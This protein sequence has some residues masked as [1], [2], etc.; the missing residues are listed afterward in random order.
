MIFSLL[1]NRLIFIFTISLIVADESWKVYDDS[2]IAIINISIDPDALE[3]IYDNA[4]SDSLHVASIQ[5][6][7]AYI[8]QSVD[9]IGFRIRGNTSRGSEK[10]SFKID[11][12][13]FIGGRDFFNVEKL[14][15]N[16][17]HNDPSII[18]SKL[19]WDMFQQIGV[20]SSRA[21]HARLYIN[22]SYYGLYI[23]I[24]HIDDS[25]VSKNYDN[26]NGNLWKC[27]WPADLTYRGD[28][29]EDYYPFVDKIQNKK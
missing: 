5:F 1:R 9:S 11:F 28:N 7:N 25:F 18:R 23:S 22:G 4:R 13:H 2:E 29:P 17:E 26:G 24:E 20:T 14:N 3:W 10:K 27:I 6:Q 21:S 19:C 16:G 12:N 8:N 15:L